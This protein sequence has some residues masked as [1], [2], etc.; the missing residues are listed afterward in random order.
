[1]ACI[2]T[3]HPLLSPG[4]TEPTGTAGSTPTDGECCTTTS[5]ARPQVLHRVQG[6]VWDAQVQYAQVWGKQM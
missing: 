4:T 3:A 5:V 6:V 2:P 1:M